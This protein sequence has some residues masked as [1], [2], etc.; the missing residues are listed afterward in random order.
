[1]SDRKIFKLD[2]S[3]IG[4]LATLVQL[5]IM[6]QTSV[7]DHMRQLRA[8]STEEGALVLTPEYKEYFEGSI[9]KLLSDV[10]EIKLGQVGDEGIAEA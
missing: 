6:T 10:E 8:E 7:V 1:M 9:A 5:A 4:Q 3:L 2:D